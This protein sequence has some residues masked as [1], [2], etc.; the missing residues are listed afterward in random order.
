M[1]NAEFVSA[2]IVVANSV[3]QRRYDA[4]EQRDATD[5]CV[6][7]L[8][9]GG[10]SIVIPHSQ[11]LMNAAYNSRI[12]INQC[13]LS[14]D[15]SRIT[16][17]ERLK[18][19]LQF[20]PTMKQNL[21]HNLSRIPLLYLSMFIQTKKLCVSEQAVRTASVLYANVITLLVYRMFPFI[22]FA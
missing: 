16:I 4:T 15:Q 18:R 20:A 1:C 5:V 22:G 17:S 2:L 21:V 12:A 14:V 9:V 11:S 6:W 10:R 13:K 3:P 7:S 19:A 8:C